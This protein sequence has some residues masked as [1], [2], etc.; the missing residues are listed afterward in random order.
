LLCG[1]CNRLVGFLRDDPAAFDR[2]AGY[3]RSPPA[4]K[5]LR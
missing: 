3:L 4:R 2:M 5:V 1:V